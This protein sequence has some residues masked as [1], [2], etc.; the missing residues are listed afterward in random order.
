M[1]HIGV[2][3]SGGDAP[4]MN[5]ALRAVARTAFANGCKVTAFFAG[6][7][8][9][10]SG[11]CMEVTTRTVGGIINCGGTIIRSARSE[12]FRTEDGRRKA[13]SSM[14]RLGVEGLIV[15]GG[16]GSLTGADLFY[17]E[18]GLP[19]IGLPGTI[20]NDLAGTDYTIGFDTA[21]NTALEAID[22]I[23]DTAYS[24]DRIFVV[25]VMGRRKG[26][27]ALE[28]GIA[29]GAESILLPEVPLDLDK[30]VHALRKAGKRS[31]IVVAAEGAIRAVDA[32]DYI[33]NQTGLEARYIVLGHMQRGGAPTAFDRVLASR[34]GAYGV[35]R[36]LH[37]NTDQMVGVVGNSL[38]C[39]SIRSVLECD[40]QIDTEKLRIAEMLG[41]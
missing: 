23:R 14:E 27:I 34:L 9:L 12:A 10:I 2:L 20:D 7:E 5:A 3:A 38:V 18:N 29:G 32:V 30:M 36:L 13:A 22:K 16:D 39:T 11:D 6:Y 41:R 33:Q 4:G 24:H 25:E 8:G 1:K 15:I 28:V 21:V 19:L 37:G 40:K 35:E 31:C 17:K 26:F